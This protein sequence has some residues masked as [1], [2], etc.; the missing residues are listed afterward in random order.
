MAGSFD[1]YGSP[2]S[3]SH[4][5]ELAHKVSARAAGGIGSNTHF[6]FTPP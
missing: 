5:C 1:T 4:S 2:L 6:M 3:E